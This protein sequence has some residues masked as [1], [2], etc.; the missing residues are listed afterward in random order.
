MFSPDQWAASTGVA[1]YNGV[2]TQSLRFDDGSSAYLNRTPSSAGNR[3]TYTY[4]LWVKRANIKTSSLIVADATNTTQTGFTS[5]GFDGASKLNIGGY[6]S[7]LAVTNAVFRDVGSWYHIV[8]AVDTTSGTSSERIKIY[9]NG[10]LQTL[11]NGA[12]Y[13]SQNTDTGIN[14]D[15]VHRIG[16]NDPASAYADLY[17]SEVNFVD[18]S[19]LTPT[20]FG[21]TKNGVWIPIEYTGSYGTNGFRLQFN[22]TGTGTASSSTIGADTSGN[23]NHFS[24]NGIV[25][26]D[27]DMP[28][29]PENNFATLNSIDPFSGTLSDGNLKYNNGTSF[30]ASRG[31]I[32][33]PSSGKWY[34]EVLNTTLTSG[35][36][37]IWA[38][39]ASQ[40]TNISAQPNNGSTT[41]FYGIYDDTT[42]G[43]LSNGS[44]S[45]ST[46]NTI[47]ANS[48]LQFA[49]DADNNK[50][51]V[52]IDNSYYSNATTT[53]GNPSAGTNPTESID[54]AG[55][56]PFVGAYNNTGVL[57]TGQDSTFA[58][59]ISAGGNTDGNGKGDFKYAVPSGYLAL[60]TANLPEPTISPNANTQA[61]DYFNT[62]LYT[63][64]GSSNAITGV[65]FQPDWVW[66][67]ERSNNTSGGNFHY[68]SDS[69]RGVNAI[70]QSNTTG[71]ESTGSNVGI[72]SFD[73][74]G[75]TMGSYGGGNANQSG[76]TYVSWN[77]KAEGNA[78][79]NTDGTITS[80]VSANTDAGFSIV[81]YNGS[82]TAGDT[83]G[84]GLNSAPTCIHWKRRNATGNW[85]AY[86]EVLG[87]G[88]YLNLDRTNG[89]DTGASPVNGTAPTN[90][91]ITLSSLGTINNSAGTYV[92][93]AF[94]DV[95]GYSKFGSYIGNGNADG[96]FVYTGFRPAFVLVKRSSTTGNWT[97]MDNTRK[98]FNF[99]N[100]LLYPN[101]SQ[102][103]NT[104]DGYNGS[105]FVSNGFKIRGGSSGV[106]TDVSGTGTY[107]YMAFAENPFKYANAR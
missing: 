100:T 88:G 101:G 99:N 42:L 10:T 4:S 102:A 54:L 6:N 65:G 50:L 31:T 74:D 56:R 36:V 11:T 70:L 3:R 41:G 95:E 40:D 39:V 49:I 67:K 91:V 22:Q 83:I 58:G 51:F 12:G 43:I 7:N 105:D 19:Q 35:S 32:A 103:E 24:S 5:F 30:R 33:I 84:H 13:P 104:D 44:Q 20:S 64:N 21:E 81:T 61:D 18:G 90:S 89:F 96:T 53:N 15:G 87:T 75:F 82:G 106:G 46:S 16:G 25:A 63:G 23:A 98:T 77:W 80:S 69:V 78:V 93:Y 59:A 62:V 47:S 60:C 9:V 79:S 14:V 94:H 27:C 2:A 107:I 73:S 38:G 34:F 55:Y 45:S 8:L 71:A 26:S 37:A 48:I 68:L 28:D 85:M 97:L 57:N 17:M 86:F 1:F 72:N 92:C 52:G 66:Q 76:E 29:S